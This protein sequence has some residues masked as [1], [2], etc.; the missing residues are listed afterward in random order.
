METHCDKSTFFLATLLLNP[1]IGTLVF[2]MLGEPLVKRK[3]NIE[4]TVK[5]LSSEN[6]SLPFVQCIV[7]FD[8]CLSSAT[9]SGLTGVIPLEQPGVKCFSQGSSSDSSWLASCGKLATS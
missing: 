3:R 4:Q 6:I 7:I 8:K 2:C 5:S 1:D 9:S